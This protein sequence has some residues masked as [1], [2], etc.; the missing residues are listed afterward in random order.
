MSDNDE[1]LFPHEE[2]DIDLSLDCYDWEY[3]RWYKAPVDLETPYPNNWN[4]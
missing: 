2:D 1:D 3:L 4:T